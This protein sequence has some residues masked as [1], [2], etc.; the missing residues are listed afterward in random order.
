MAAG[1]RDLFAWVLGWK[2][3]VPSV[4]G[5]YRVAA[6]QTFVTGAAAAQHYTT[7]AAAGQTFVT[8]AVEAQSESHGN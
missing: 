4:S 6:S 2:S 5:P 7:G 3:S 1:F 8:G